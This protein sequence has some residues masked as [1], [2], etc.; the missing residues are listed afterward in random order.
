MKK[1]CLL[2]LLSLS[3]FLGHA[4]LNMTLRSQLTYGANLNDIWGW[5]DEDGTE[6]AIVGLVNGVSI[7]SLADP[8]NAV[9]VV[10]IPGQNSLWRDIKTWGNYAY[11]TTDQSGTTEGFWSLTFP[12]LPEA[13][14]FYNWNPDLPELGVLNT[15][16]N[17]YIDEF[18]YCYLSGCN[19]NAAASCLWMLQPRPIDAD[20][21][22]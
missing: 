5:V 19:V 11:V 16:H 14:P 2:L 20:L 22:R 1:T 13:A 21:C 12:N 6:Y 4:Q 18:G 17:L 7:V 8:D 3:A 15:C 10:F 9:E